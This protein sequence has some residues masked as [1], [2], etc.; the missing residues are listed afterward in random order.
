VPN[1][2]EPATIEPADAPVTYA[3]TYT[4]AYPVTMTSPHVGEVRPGDTYTSEHPVVHAAFEP[5]NDAAVQAE[6][7]R[8][9][10]ER[11]E[12]VAERVGKSATPSR[13]TSRKGA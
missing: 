11:G 6:R 2:P 8:V 5:A 13:R 1:D 10:P 12:P 7:A 3:Y 9:E 4:G